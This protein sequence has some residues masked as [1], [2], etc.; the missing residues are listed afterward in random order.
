MEHLKS[1]PSFFYCSDVFPEE[2]AQGVS[3]FS[4][5]L[6]SLPNVYGTHHIGAST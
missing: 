1:Q 6:A 4:T 2:P 3:S 5:P